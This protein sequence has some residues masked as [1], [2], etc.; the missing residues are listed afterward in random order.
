MDGENWT[1]V[2]ETTYIYDYTIN[3][4][5][6]AQF[7]SNFGTMQSTMKYMY[8]IGIT[9]YVLQRRRAGRWL[10]ETRARHNREN[11][12][13]SPRIGERLEER[14]VAEVLIGQTARYGAQLL[15]SVLT[16]TRHSVYLTSDRPE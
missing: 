4:L 13:D 2:A 8:D 15:W 14:E 7:F 5:N 3:F 9:G 16:F 12:I 10:V 11:L 1:K 6:V